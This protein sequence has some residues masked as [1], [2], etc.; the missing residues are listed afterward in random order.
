MGRN[1]TCGVENEEK[2]R[3]HSTT[4]G[5]TPLRLRR[6]EIPHRF[7]QKSLKNEKKPT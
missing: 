7:L 2:N 6:G 4:G 5:H 1:W 3:P